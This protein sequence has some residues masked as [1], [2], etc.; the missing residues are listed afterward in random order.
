MVRVK[1][2][3]NYQKLFSKLNAK[4]KYCWK[5]NKSKPTLEN[6]AKYKYISTRLKKTILHFEILKKKSMINS[7]NLGQ[8]YK[9]V[10][11]KSKS[12]SGI[13][14]LNGTTGSLL[15]SDKEKADCR[16]TK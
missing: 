12:K 5:F 4:K 1:T 6:K 14:P 3:K 9:Y 8:F 15:F 16:F 11:K 2:G 13:P 7:K 10:N